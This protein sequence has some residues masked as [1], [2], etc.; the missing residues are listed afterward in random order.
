MWGVKINVAGHID[1]RY[2]LVACRMRSWQSRG[3]LLWIAIGSKGNWCEE[4]GVEGQIHN[5]QALHDISPLE[6]RS[7]AKT[8]SWKA[9]KSHSVNEVCVSLAQSQWRA[10]L[11]F[12][13][14][15]SSQRTWQTS[16]IVRHPGPCFGHRIESIVSNINQ[17]KPLPHDSHPALVNSIREINTTSEQSSKL[18]GIV[19]GSFLPAPSLTQQ[20]VAYG[21]WYTLMITFPRWSEWQFTHLGLLPQHLEYSYSCL[22]DMKKTMSHCGIYY[23]LCLPSEDS[24]IN[25]YPFFTYSE[26]QSSEILPA[27]QTINSCLTPIQIPT[28]FLLT[29]SNC[30]PAYTAIRALIPSMYLA[31]RLSL[32]FEWICEIPSIKLTAVS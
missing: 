7:A 32:S 8:C 13:I 10:I 17:D 28:I 9:R 18:T 5:G 29:M 24:S 14:S 15:K 19:P 31:F 23:K 21:T 11:T 16:I 2:L 22:E 6:C 1:R 25:E 20:N 26:G 4:G 3:L 12:I 27:P 30:P